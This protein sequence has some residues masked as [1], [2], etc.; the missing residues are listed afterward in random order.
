MGHGCGARFFL[1]GLLGSDGGLVPGYSGGSVVGCACV[2]GYRLICG[3]GL[4][5]L[6]VT[7]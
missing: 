3:D 2:V 4:A 7:V 1:L 5:V 6:W